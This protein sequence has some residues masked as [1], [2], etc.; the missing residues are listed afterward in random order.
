MEL[1]PTDL[2]QRIVLAGMYLV[3]SDWEKA[4]DHYLMALE[5]DPANQEVVNRLNDLRLRLRPRYEQITLAL[6]QFQPDNPKYLL[7]LGQ[8]YYEGGNLAKTIEFDQRYLEA[9]PD[10]IAAWELIGDAYKRTGA[11][12][13]AMDA[14]RQILRLDSNNVRAYSELAAIYVDQGNIDQAIAEAKRALAIDAESAQA[15]YV[16]G[17]AAVKWGM[18]KLET[19]HPGRELTKMPYNFKELFK[20][21]ATNYFEKARKEPHWRNFAIEQINYLNQFYPNPE[22]RFMAPPA[23][24]DTIV[25]PPPTD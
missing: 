8:F 20:N 9:K 11:I 7:D 6:V 5:A 17:E 10:D 24:R 25:F 21:I 13:Q 12:P 4:T 18:R 16:M 23:E 22:D 19:D 15:N 3:L 1:E 2:P 14:Y